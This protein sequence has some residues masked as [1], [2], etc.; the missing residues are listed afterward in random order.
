LEKAAGLLEYRI[1]EFGQASLDVK[2]KLEVSSQCVVFS[3]SE[4]ISLKVKGER[5]EDIAAAINLAIAKRVRNLVNKIGI[6]ADLIFSGG[7]SHNPG[8]KRAL[9]E[10]VGLQITETRMDMSYAGA[11]GAA[12]FAN[13]NKNLAVEGVV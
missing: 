6:E 5:R 8:M 1:D 4:V 12:I 3:E 7:V 10:A 11:L 13:Q 2:N 9:E